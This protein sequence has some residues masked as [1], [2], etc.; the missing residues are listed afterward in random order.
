MK[1]SSIKK[2]VDRCEPV[3]GGNMSHVIE[4]TDQS[5]VDEVINAGQPVLV[6][7]WAP[8]CGPCRAVAPTIEAL[9]SDYVGRAKVAKLN[10]EEQQQIAGAMGIRAI[11]TVAVFNGEKV[12]AVQ[13]GALSKQAYAEMLDS[14]LTDGQPS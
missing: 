14:A 11:P 7:F 9:A 12:V 2:S 4:L 13:A 6:D 10:V 8:W 5:F 3:F 1:C